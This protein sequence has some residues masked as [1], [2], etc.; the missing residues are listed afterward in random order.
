MTLVSPESNGL[1]FIKPPL[2]EMTPV[3]MGTSQPRLHPDLHMAWASAVRVVV[4][5]HH[6]LTLKFLEDAQAFAIEKQRK[7]GYSEPDSG[8]CCESC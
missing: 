6:A 7:N 4:G 2:G 5:R 8:L 3:L 1:A